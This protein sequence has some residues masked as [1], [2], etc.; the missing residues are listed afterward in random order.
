MHKT[1]I[2]GLLGFGLIFFANTGGASAAQEDL[3]LSDSKTVAAI[4]LTDVVD[5]VQKE[6]VE[7]EEDKTIKHVVEKEETLTDIA[8]EHETTWQRIFNKNQQIESPDIINPGDELTIPAED[9]ELDEREVPQSY[10]APVETETAAAVTSAPSRSTAAASKPAASTARG[11]TSGNGYSYGYCT[12]HVKNLRPDLPNNLGNANT[13][14]SR[15][16]AQGYATGSKPRAGAVAM[17]TTGYM[18]VA[19]VTSVNGDGTVNLSEMNFK[20]WGVVSSRTA[21]ANQFVYIY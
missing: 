21:P 2:T 17:A 10:I 12:W 19:Y 18:H 13:W 8:K 11:S 9:E 3:P 7:S 1:V 15:A 20:G 6:K 14:A 5:E 4:K 16:A